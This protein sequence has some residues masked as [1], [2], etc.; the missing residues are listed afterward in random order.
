[1]LCIGDMNLW[2]CSLLSVSVPQFNDWIVTYQYLV[3]FCRM[4]LLVYA[5][6]VNQDDL[7][8]EAIRGIEKLRDNRVPLKAATAC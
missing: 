4:P 6:P 1:M 5:Y 7:Q 2:F 8:V 3:G